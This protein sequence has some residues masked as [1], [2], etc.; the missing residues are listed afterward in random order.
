MARR[1]KAQQ[2]L[3]P[4]VC[5]GQADS[6]AVGRRVA[7]QQ[8]VVERNSLRSLAMELLDRYLQAVQFWLPKKQSRDIIAEL[9]EDLRSQIE[10]KET[11]LGRQLNEGE[12]EA[13]LKRCGSPLAVASR[14]LPQRY[15]IGPTLFPLYRFVLGI[16]LLGCVVPRTLVWIGFLIIDPADR[17][18]LHMG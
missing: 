6:E 9:S 8:Q 18:Y 5:G 11:E 2:T 15:L 17:G 16:L 12:L 1:R 10:E 7:K 14:Y 13:I 4:A 3:L